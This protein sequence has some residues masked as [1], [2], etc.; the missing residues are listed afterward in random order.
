MTRPDR[1][2]RWPACVCRQH[3]DYY[4]TAP[5]EHLENAEPIIEATLACISERCPDVRFRQ[6]AQ[7]QLL[8]I[9]SSPNYRREFKHEGGL[10]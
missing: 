2:H 10:N 9:Q 3:W 8:K 6:H 1:C 7:I 4:A 5:L